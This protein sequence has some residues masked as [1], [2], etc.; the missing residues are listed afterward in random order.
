MIP[1][2]AFVTLPLGCENKLLPATAEAIH[3]WQKAAHNLGK[4]AG[5]APFAINLGANDGTSLGDPTAFWLTQK[6]AT[7]VAVEYEQQFE[8]KLNRAYSSPGVLKIVGEPASPSTIG[9]ILKRGGTP[10]DPLVFKI[11]IDRYDAHVMAEVLRLGYRPY[12]AIFE[13]NLLVPPGISFSTGFTAG[14]VTGTRLYGASLS[15]W[16]SVFAP[17]TAEYVMV[18]VHGENVL[19]ARRS[20]LPSLHNSAHQGLL[21]TRKAPRAEPEVSTTCAFEMVSKI[22]FYGP[23]LAEIR[24]EWMNGTSTADG[25][26]EQIRAQV[27]TDQSKYL[28][29]GKA[30]QHFPQGLTAKDLLPAEVELAEGVKGGD[31]LPRVEGACMA[32]AACGVQRISLEH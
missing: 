6:N 31:P 25:T 2:C 21:G 10:N 3:G 30:K 20:I 32:L 5:V 26:V 12:F 7:G 24:R 11:D 29:S 8:A 9:A 13:V 1:L 17:Y 18:G 27:A 16:V 4:S 23:K 14:V 28:T 15:K 19:F 22:D